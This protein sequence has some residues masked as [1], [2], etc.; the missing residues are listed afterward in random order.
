MLT[1]YSDSHRLQNGRSE[2][3]DGTL[4]PCFENPSRADMVLAAVRRRGLGDVV[5]PRSHGA[6]PILRVHDQDYVRFLETAWQCWTELGRD[7]D[8]L[9]KMWQIR[10]LREAIPEHVEGQLCYY[11]MDC[12]TPITAG[13]WQAATGAADVALSGAERLIGGERAVFALT[14]PPG[15]HAARDYCGGYC[16]F[17]NAAIAAQALRDHGLRRVAVLDVDY[18]HGNGTQ[19]IFYNRSDVLFLSIHG[20]PRTEYPFF[21]GFADEKGEG[22]GLGYNFN[23]PLAAGSCVS[24]W[25]FALDCA[26]EQIARFGAEALAAGSCVST[27]FFALDCA[28]EQIARF[29]AEALVVSL[30]VDTFRGDP[31]SRFQLDTPDFLTQGERLAGLKLP[32]LFCLEGGYAVGPIGDNVAN[33]LAGFES[34]G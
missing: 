27:W 16:F 12:G 22:E 6:A 14:R 28:L 21:L 13:T 19:D 25:F 24:T 18:H 31:I 26:L 4:K 30:G 7:C 20:D 33:V 34:R 23:F 9:P 1:I 8:A 32:T 5:H 15:H 2:L 10:R 11:S 17:N 3:I 29:G